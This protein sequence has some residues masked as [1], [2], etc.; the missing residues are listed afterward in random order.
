MF[1]KIFIFCV[2]SAT[3]LLG[4]EVS[5]GEWFVNGG[6]GANVNVVRYETLS[7]ASPGA[8]MPLIMGA[9]YAIDSSFALFGSVSPFL[10][11]GSVALN[12]RLGAKYFLPVLASPFLPYVS[13]ALTPGVLMPTSRTGSHWS[14]GLSPG[15]GLNYFLTADFL[16]GLHVYV[17]PVISRID[18]R[19]H[20]ELSTTAYLDL[21][22][23]L[24]S[25]LQS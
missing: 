23:K 24:P 25:K 1:M 7:H 13:L 21:T 6:L 11:P 9:D 20:F 4:Y 2:L 17:N 16:L 19:N 3:N 18:F 5:G 15:V 10:A 8:Q 12:T 22:F 14:I